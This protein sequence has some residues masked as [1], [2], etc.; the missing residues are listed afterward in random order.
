MKK[1]DVGRAVKKV[2]RMIPGI[3][4]YQDRETLRE[5]DKKLRVQV[6]RKVDDLI[7]VVEWIKTDQVKKGGWKRIKALEDLERDLEKASKTLERAARGFSPVFE[8]AFRVDE[9]VLQ[10]VY[11]FDK[12]F[13]GLLEP[14]EKGIKELTEKGVIPESSKID[15]IRELL[16]KFLQ[17]TAKRD[18]LLKGLGK[19]S[20][21]KPQA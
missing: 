6:S 16:K 17:K 13:W 3:G 21:Q 9:E 5:A 7:G 8:G 1:E 4:S 11:E 18:D 12:G 20:D 15:A 14:I 2:A 19:S 10:R